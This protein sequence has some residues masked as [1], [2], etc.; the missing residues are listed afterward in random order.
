MTTCPACGTV[1]ARHD[2]PGMFIRSRPCPHCAAPIQWSN[3]MR[4][5][6]NLATLVAPIIGVIIWLVSVRAVMYLFYL[7]LALC[8]VSF[9]LGRNT[10]LVLVPGPKEVKP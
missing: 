9:V 4:S 10:R 8:I 6:A 5:L 7:T 2:L 1:I 3:R